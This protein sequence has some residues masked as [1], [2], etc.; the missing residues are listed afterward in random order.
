[1]TKVV[2]ILFN[3]MFQTDSEVSAKEKNIIVTIIFF[4]A[5]VMLG[6]FMVS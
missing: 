2:S 3:K 4:I 5:I 1:M 6:Y